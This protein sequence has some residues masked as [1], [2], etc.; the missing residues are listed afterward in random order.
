VCAYYLGVREYEW[1]LVKA[2][3]NRTKHGI[4]FADVVGVFEDDRSLTIEDASTNEE[5]Y[6][7]LGTDFMGR[8]L[9]VVYAYRGDRIRLVSAR[10]ATAPQRD[11]YERKR[12]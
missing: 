1:D 9:V 8:L 4:D 5:R 3:A 2:A 10:K 7:T 11:A 12:R 6:K